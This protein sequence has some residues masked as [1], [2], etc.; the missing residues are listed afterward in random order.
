MKPPGA[1]LG[2]HLRA[3]SFRI[4]FGGHFS[5]GCQP[6]LGIDGA[7]NRR[8]IGCRQERRRAAAEENRLHRPGA[9][10]QDLAAS[11]ISPMARPA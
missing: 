11:R 6:E 1:E 7:Q 3:D 10:G 4:R 2:Q 9:S 8:Q 5:V